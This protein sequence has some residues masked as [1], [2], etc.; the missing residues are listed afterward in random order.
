MFTAGERA[1][2]GIQNEVKMSYTRQMNHVQATEA[3]IS[4]QSGAASTEAVCVCLV[5][6]GALWWVKKGLLG[7]M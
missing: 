2:S 1:L 3:S 5:C 6:L 7:S 4:Y